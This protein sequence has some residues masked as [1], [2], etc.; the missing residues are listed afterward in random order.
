[1]QLLPG[2]SVIVRL[3]ST[4]EADALLVPNEAVIATGTGLV[5][6]VYEDDGRLR[7]VNVAIGSQVGG[8][9]EIR[10]GLAAGQK[11]I[12][13]EYLNQVGQRSL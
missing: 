12:V 9:T 2:M 10:S 5:V 4:A 7:A 1:M 13:F 11:I 6:T 8:Q 3:A